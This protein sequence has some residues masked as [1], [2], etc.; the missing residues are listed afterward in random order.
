[1]GVPT[2]SCPAWGE[3]VLEISTR[4]TQNLGEHNH[5]YILHAGSNPSEAL[6]FD[7]EGGAL[8]RLADAG[9]DV[10]LHVG[11]EGLG[12]AHRGGAL[13]LSQGCGGDAARNIIHGGSSVQGMLAVH[14]SGWEG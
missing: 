3:N 14:R 13:A 8:G 2:A 9:E 12:Q 6:T 4:K 7:P 1:M 11:S 10:E 5:S